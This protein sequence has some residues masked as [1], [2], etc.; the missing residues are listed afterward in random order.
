[1]L[2]TKIPV[3]AVGYNFPENGLTKCFNN[4]KFCLKLKFAINVILNFGRH[5]EN[6]CILCDWRRDMD[7]CR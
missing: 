1:M 6:F 7:L 3:L 5:E 4:F 2:T